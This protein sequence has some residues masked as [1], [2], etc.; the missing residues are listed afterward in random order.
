[1]VGKT[2]DELFYLDHT[3]TMALIH[4]ILLLLISVNLDTLER[5][6]LGSLTLLV[7][8]LGHLL[9]ESRT[10][11]HQTNVLGRGSKLLHGSDILQVA[12]SGQGLDP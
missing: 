4:L 3:S 11:H 2:I 1:M 10:L 7:E 8:I 12:I 6:H 5:I 9:S